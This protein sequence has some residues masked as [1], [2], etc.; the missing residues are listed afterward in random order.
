MGYTY[1]LYLDVLIALLAAN[2]LFDYLLLWATGEVSGNFSNKKR[3]S[4]GAL[5]G[6]LYFL[7]VYFARLEFIPGYGYLRFPVTILA[8]G[9]GMIWVAFR[10]Q[11]WRKFLS[12]LGFFVGIGLVAGGAGV[13]TAY[14]TGDG[15]SPNPI[16]GTLMAIAAILLIAELG[17]GVVHRRLW[18]KV[19]YVPIEIGIGG[20]KTRINALVDTGNRL[21]DPLTGRAVVVVELKHLAEIIPDPLYTALAKFSDDFGQIDSLLQELDWGS[22]FCLLPY[23]S[24]GNTNGLMPGLRPDYVKVTISG[25]QLNLHRV[26]VGICQEPLDSAG[27]YH[28]L[29]PPDVIGAVAKEHSMDTAITKRGESLNA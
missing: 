29:V 15:M 16:W 24:L 25:G 26:I 23:A 6:A 8:V 2:F 10:P 9:G 13:A 1:V 18:E 21:R 12:L 14:V 17:W 20:R 28:A 11:T 22:R 5:L 7:L 4:L 27:D 19:Y 3:L